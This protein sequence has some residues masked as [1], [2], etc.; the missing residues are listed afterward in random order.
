MENLLN[1]AKIVLALS[2]AYVWI[3]RYDNVV[4]EFKQFGLNDLTRNFVGASKIAMATLLITSIWYP[5]LTLISAGIMGLFMIA[6]QFFHF[7]VK[8]PFVKHLPSLILLI[9]SALLAL[10]SIQ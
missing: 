10:A 9:L 6:A 3:F 8:N 5:S 2:V 7:K 1:L 4:S